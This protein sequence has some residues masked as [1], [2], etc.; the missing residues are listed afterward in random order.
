[1]AK[2]TAIRS[3]DHRA[4]QGGYGKKHDPEVTFGRIG[5]DTP[6]SPFN[7]QRRAQLPAPANGVGQ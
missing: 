4:A 3:K 1:M 7:P 5:G 6:R 2:I